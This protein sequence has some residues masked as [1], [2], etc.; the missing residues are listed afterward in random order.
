[1]LCWLS[2]GEGPLGGGGGRGQHYKPSVG[3]GGRLRN[4]YLAGGGGGVAEEMTG[5]PSNCP[6]PPA[7]K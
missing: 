4:K 1:M 5:L 2:N 3:G 7:D 6:A